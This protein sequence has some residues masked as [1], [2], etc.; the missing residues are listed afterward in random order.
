M[1]CLHIIHLDKFAEN[2][3][4]FII[5]YV[6]EINDEH[7]FVLY[8]GIKKYKFEINNIPLMYIDNFI[9]I[10]RNS[11]IYKLAIESDCIIFNGLFS[12]E[13]C[14]FKLPRGTIKKSFVFL[15]GDD[16]YGIY[17]LKN[18][19]LKTKISYWLKKKVIENSAGV[20]NLV[21][22]DYK[23]LKQLCV[24]K[25]KHFIAQMS[26]NGLS[27]DYVT[28]YNCNLKSKSP[29]KI[30]LGNSA[31]PTNQHIQMLNIL[32]KFKNNDIC[33]ICPLSYGDKKYANEVI[34]YGTLQFGDK[35]KP[36]LD[37]ID[38]NSYFSFISDISVAIFNNN[39]QQAMG[40]INTALG[41][42]CKVYIRSDSPLWEI[43]KIER[44]Y[45]VEKIEKISQMQY[46]DFVSPINN[47][48]ENIEL[49]KKYCGVTY[50][51]KQWKYFFN[52]FDK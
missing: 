11:T 34:E 39:R 2:Y 26:D 42:G 12:S 29:I 13:R 46:D 47:Q 48:E 15:W 38:L 27:V 8:S 19:P 50:Q 44:G 10:K 31:T 25:G 40:N 17:N 41:M 6:K 1:K 37:Y 49:F 9:Q 30:L 33:I 16:F 18:M 28:K 24:P 43:Y 35:F 21:S 52:N 20:I 7:F 45:A 23:V 36:L 3:I 14:L 51:S 5:T 4:K 22:T 32:S